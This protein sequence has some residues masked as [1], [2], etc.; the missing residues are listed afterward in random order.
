MSKAIYGMLDWTQSTAMAWAMAI[1]CNDEW[2]SFGVMSGHDRKILSLSQ[3]EQTGGVGHAH[4]ER[5]A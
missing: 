5:P 4:P 2:A 3:A 1:I